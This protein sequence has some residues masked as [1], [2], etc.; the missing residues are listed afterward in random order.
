MSKRLVPGN[1]H[2]AGILVPPLAR[3]RAL[4]WRAQTIG[5]VCF[6][7]QA[8]R[9]NANPAVAGMN[10]FGGEVW[11]DFRCNAVHDLDFKKIGPGHAIVAIAGNLSHVVRRAG[12]H[13]S[14]RLTFAVRG[15]PVVKAYF[16]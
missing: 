3:V 16:L 15:W 10:V 12:N 4:H 2:E 5:I 6:L 9:P 1:G 11:Q 8:Q 14:S 13:Y 7:D